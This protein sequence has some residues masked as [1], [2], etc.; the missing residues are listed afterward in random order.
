M[1]RAIGIPDQDAGLRCI[2]D[3]LDRAQQSLLRAANVIPADLWKTSSRPGVWSPA[4]LIAHVV[5]VERKAIAAADRILR[6]QPMRIPLMQRLRLPLALSLV[7]MRLYRVK[8]PIPVDPQFLREKDA[9][10]AELREVRQ[11]TLAFMEETR[12]RDLSQYWW[13]HP[14]VGSLNTYEWFSFL[15]SHQI[16]HEKQMREIAASL[17]VKIARQKERTWPHIKQQ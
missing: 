16:R 4:E 8:A 2:F 17:N 1:N 12:D 14:F 11:R 6:K 9:M 13:R 5:T 3:K 15:G 7:E 10:L